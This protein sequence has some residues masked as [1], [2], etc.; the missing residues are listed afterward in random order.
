MIDRVDD[1]AFC[2]IAAGQDVFH[3]H[4]HVIPRRPGDGLGHRGGFPA[5]V[6]LLTAGRGGRSVRCGP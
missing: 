6:T 1:C 3:F 5:V 4:T 2:E